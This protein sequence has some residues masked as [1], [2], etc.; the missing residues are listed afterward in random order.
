MGEEL[1]PGE[2]QKVDRKQWVSQVV[3]ALAAFA[4]GWLGAGPPGNPS[5]CFRGFFF[6]FPVLSFHYAMS[7]RS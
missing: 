4:H 7:G 6:I 5:M 2:G 1:F 3:G